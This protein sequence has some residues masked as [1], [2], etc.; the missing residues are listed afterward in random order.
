[1]HRRWWKKKWKQYKEGKTNN[2]ADTL[3]RVKWQDD[4]SFDGI[5]VSV[6]PDLATIKSEANSAIHPQ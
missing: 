3:S 6:A 2:V 1:M 4:I 5:K